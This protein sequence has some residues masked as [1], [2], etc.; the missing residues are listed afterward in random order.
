MSR[1]LR[2]ALALGFT[3]M[4]VGF[5]TD[6]SAA[7]DR[8]SGSAT[9]ILSSLPTGTVALPP[10]AKVPSSIPAHEKVAGF[11]VA[12]SRGRSDYVGLVASTKRAKL[13]TEG[14]GN[15]NAAGEA[16][17]AQAQ[18][19]RRSRHPGETETAWMPNLQPVL[20]MSTSTQQGQHPTVEA[21]HSERIAEAG[22]H[23]SLD[24]IDA[25]VD[26]VTRGVRLIGRTSVPLE[27][28]STVLGGGRVYAA[29]DQQSVHVIVVT[30]KERARLGQDVIFA[31]SEGDVFNSMC[32]HLRVSLKTEKGQGETATFITNVELPSLSNDRAE[33]RP[34][35]RSEGTIGFPRSGLPEPVR[36]RPL[37][38]QASAT[39]TSRDKEP[40][41]S[42]S[43]GWDARERAGF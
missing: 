7:E 33:P 38:I 32:D 37:H 14:G 41:L 9:A 1:L 17:F 43:A 39:W 3:V 28:V 31:I 22:G 42:V 16:C 11:I 35:G 19:A 2:G 34:G 20:M 18:D 13:L 6:A 26:P 21:V 29:H 12:S 30:P 15:E 10:K 4:A 40:L 23:V 36:T 8:S 27:L 25:W 5:V 24:T